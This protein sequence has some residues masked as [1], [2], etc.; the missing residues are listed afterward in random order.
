MQILNQAEISKIL[1]IGSNFLFVDSF[2]NLN[3]GID[4]R[5]TYI[6]DERH[7]FI[8]SHFTS[9]VVIP[10]AL[11]MESM[12][13]AMAL[14]IYNAEYWE[15]IAL[16]ANVNIEFLAPLH[17]QSRVDSYCKILINSAGRVE[18]EV[19]CSSNEKIVGTMK[20]T[21]YS[22]HLFDVLKKNT[23]AKNSGGSNH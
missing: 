19:T 11:I 22:S 15:G 3:L 4:G 1:D 7:K 2:E 5:A 6:F 23:I 16:V 12:L 14:T 10:G 21:Y 8:K 20:C 18:G 13:Q 17:L 9:K